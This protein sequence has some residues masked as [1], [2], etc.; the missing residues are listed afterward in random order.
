MGM[1]QRV[2]L[3]TCK[4][5]N[6]KS[7]RRRIVKTPSGELRYHHIGKLA[8]APKCGDC[9]TKLRHPCPSPGRVQPDQQVQEDRPAGLRRLAMRWL[10]WGQNH[11]RFPGGREQDRQKGPQDPDR[12]QVLEE[13]KR[14]AD[15]RPAMVVT[16]PCTFDL[17]CPL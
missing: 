2:T 16:S 17:S 8:T 9:G 11:P 1:A 3:R 5:Y 10:R 15:S 7:N 13:V 6:T 14:R 12:D 4:S